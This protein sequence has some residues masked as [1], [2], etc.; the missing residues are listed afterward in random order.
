M[1][2]GIY[3]FGGIFLIIVVLLGGIF[4]SRK[5][6]FLQNK[7]EFTESNSDNIDILEHDNETDSEETENIRKPTDMKELNYQNVTQISAWV[8]GEECFVTDEETVK[9]VVDMVSG[10]T[11]NDM[12]INPYAVGEKVYGGVTSLYLYNEE[13]L[14]YE[15]ILYGREPQTI[16]ING[17]DYHF[18]CDIDA[19]GA[20]LFYDIY[21]GIYE[22]FALDVEK[23]YN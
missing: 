17:E 12:K 18:Y 6:I 7:T 21:S 15:I 5:M 9:Q 8:Q 16:G 14:L 3:I 2:K 20:Q 22:E 19:D 10:L 23:C 13:E 4:F 1:K 11:P